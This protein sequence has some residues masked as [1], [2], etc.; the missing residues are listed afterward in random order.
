MV[1]P[2]YHVFMHAC[3]LTNSLAKCHT[4]IDISDMLQLITNSATLPRVPRLLGVY[5]VIT[6]NSWL[7]EFANIWKSY[8]SVKQLQVELHNT[9]THK[10]RYMAC[11]CIHYCHHCRVQPT[12]TM[13]SRFYPIV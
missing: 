9:H 7:R 2:L 12:F 13:P 1:W 4:H 5:P 10:H 11:T 3:M 6:S 8:G